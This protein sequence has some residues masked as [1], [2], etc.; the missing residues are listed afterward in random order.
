ML[1]EDPLDVLG[2]SHVHDPDAERMAPLIPYNLRQHHRSKR[3]EGLPELV[4]GTK[5][6]KTADMDT[7]IHVDPPAKKQAIVRNTIVPIGS[8]VVWSILL[9][10]KIFIKYFL[11]G[12]FPIA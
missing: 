5:V 7:R 6:G 9:T 11:W 10:F 4:I 3:D 1:I 2:T 8:L 12:H